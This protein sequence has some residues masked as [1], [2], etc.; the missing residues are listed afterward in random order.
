MKK[1]NKLLIGLIVIMLFVVSGLSAYAYH[2]QQSYANTPKTTV[3]Q[4]DNQESKIK[5]VITESEK[6]FKEKEN[7]SDKFEVFKNLLNKKDEVSSVNKE[8]ITNKY[9][10]IINSIKKELTELIDSKIKNNTLGAQAILD[11]QKVEEAK[12]E[13]ESLKSLLEN[14]GSDIYSNETELNT[15]TS[16]ITRLLTSYNQTQQQNEVVNS[17]PDQEVAPQVQQPVVQPTQPARR[18]NNNTANNGSSTANTNNTSGQNGGG[19]EA[20]Q[21]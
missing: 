9:N 8:E 5:K 12:K 21:Q 13:L 2:K 19:E 10:E 14:N 6:S 4:T 11:K 17:E 16:E 18:V 15:V 7:I 3:N 20:P 1:N